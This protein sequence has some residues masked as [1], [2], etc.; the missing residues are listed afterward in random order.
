M[1]KQLREK[2][3]YTHRM[4]EVNT[5]GYVLC[6][7]YGESTT[8]ATV[9][10]VLLPYYSIIVRHVACISQQNIETYNTKIN[11]GK[12]LFPALCRILPVSAYTPQKCFAEIHSSIIQIFKAVCSHKR[13]HPLLN[14]IRPGPP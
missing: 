1:L 8:C 11:C 12:S 14:L 2:H 5:Y 6:N 3:T 7:H 9:Q 4:P 10:G 13:L